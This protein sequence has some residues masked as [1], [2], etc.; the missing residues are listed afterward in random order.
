MRT[1]HPRQ[2]PRRT[3]GARA[4]W[5][6]AWQ[7]A[8][9]EAAFTDSDLQQGRR[10]ARRAEVGAISVDAGELL[11]AV[12]EGDDAWTVEVEVPV[13]SDADRRSLVGVVAAETGRIAALLAGDLAH[14]LVEHAEELGVELLPY[15]G[16]LA[17]TCSCPH[18]LD[19]CAHALAVL[20][21]VGW[22]VDA[23]P[24]VLF[25]LRGLDREMLLGD[26]HARAVGGGGAGAAGDTAGETV[27][28]LADDVEVAADAVMRARRLIELLESGADVPDGLL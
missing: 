5:G 17:A 11:A 7:R 3:G 27:A 19:P 10:I 13:L 22:L 21:Q 9:E 28:D 2:P 24:L 1:T 25:A 16:E 23:D 15:G 26:L 4:W 20:V 8:V 6:K 12:R 14:D 18:A